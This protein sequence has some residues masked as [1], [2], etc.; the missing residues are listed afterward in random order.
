MIRIDPTPNPNALKVSVGAALTAK[1]VTFANAASA[2]GHPLASA[3]FAIPGV[4]SVFIFNNYVT[5]TKSTDADWGAI[6]PQL[7]AAFAKGQGA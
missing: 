7:E 4:A 5:I 2:A 3:L 1:P 6:E